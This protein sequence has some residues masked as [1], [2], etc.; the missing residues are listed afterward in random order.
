MLAH[1]VGNLLINGDFS[2]GLWSRLAQPHEGV[3]CATWRQTFAADRW[4]V[5]C[6]RPE[7]T[8]VWQGMSDDV[9][10]HSSATC[11]LEIRGAAGVAQSVFV[12]Q[13]I[14]AAEVAR[15]RRQHVFS[16]WMRAEGSEATEAKVR[17]VLGSPGERDAFAVVKPVLM[18][19]MVFPTSRWVHLEHPVDGRALG[20]A[21]LSLELELPAKLLARNGASVRLAN[22]RL[23]D[24]SPERPVAVETALARRFFQRYD[25]TRINSLGRALVVNAHELHFQFTFEEMRAFPACTLP[26]DEEVLRVFDLEGIP[27]AGFTC[28]V[29]YRSRGSVIIR[30]TKENHGLRDGFLSFVG[31]EGAIL[32]DA[33]L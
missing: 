1:P 9:P 26:H 19:E 7:G 12:G 13:R 30:A 28:D 3:E 5:R 8:P 6:A 32:L 27:Q 18:E 25:S 15:Y 22:V 23:D 10:P 21:G 29:T 16:A 2:P 14:E 4:S 17:L 33:E 11:S 24:G 20:S 31:T